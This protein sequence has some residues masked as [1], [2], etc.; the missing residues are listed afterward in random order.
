MSTPER[1]SLRT[2]HS[3]AMGHKSVSTVDSDG[4]TPSSD[5]ASFSIS[6]LRVVS[7]F[8]RANGESMT[9]SLHHVLSH[10]LTPDRET[11]AEMPQ[12]DRQGSGRP[13]DSLAAKL[14]DA[15]DEQPRTTG[16]TSA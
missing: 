10:A 14:A 9:V 3:L 5:G 1:L 2:G 13:P 16:E 8:K 12:G 6:D 7:P 11:D 4:L 15:S